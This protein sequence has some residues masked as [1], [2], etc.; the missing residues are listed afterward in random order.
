MMR[1]LAWLAEAAALALAWGVFGLLPLDAASAAGGWIG[2]AIGPRLPVSRRARRNLAAA[3]PE[4]DAAARE[5]IVR[6]VWD[7]LGRTGAEFPHLAEFRFGP[8]ERV[9][10]EG[11]EHLVAMRDDGRPG[12][13]FSGHLGNWELGGYCASRN[14]LRLNLVY[15]AANN[16][17]TEW[18]YRRGRAANGAEL[19]PKGMVGARRAYALLRE[20]QHLALLLDQKMNDGVAVP[21]FGRPAMTATALARFALRFRC[22]VVPAHVERLAGARFRIVIE[23]PLVLPEGGDAAAD[24]NALMEMVNRRIETWIRARPGQWLWLHNRWER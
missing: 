18:L 5:A 2:R 4:L 17:Y 22:P 13:V 9:E 20:G 3:F 7:N 1:R 16:P 21:F 14:G 19:V 6:E 10:V 8:G 24:T 11:I 23:P 12:L 15:R